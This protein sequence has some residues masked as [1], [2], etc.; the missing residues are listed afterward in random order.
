MKQFRYLITYLLILFFITCFGYLN[1]HRFDLYGMFPFECALAF[2]M[3]LIPL[4]PFACGALIGW[5]WKYASFS[6]WHVI[7]NILLLTVL[8]PLGFTELTVAIFGA[9][10]FWG[11]LAKIAATSG[12][13]LLFLVFAGTLF[14]RLTLFINKFRKN[15]VRAD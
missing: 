8:L 9:P 15:C 1:G 5:N 11:S 12:T 7:I 3:L 10:G 13:R 4:L 6:H 2:E 14:G